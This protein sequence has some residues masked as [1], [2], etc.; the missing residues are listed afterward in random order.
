MMTRL[1]RSLAATRQSRC[2]FAS[3]VILAAGLLSIGARRACAQPAPVISKASPV[4]AGSLRPGDALRL[5]V[6]REPE[7][8]GEFMVDEHGQVTLPRLGRRTV[9]DVP[10]DSV[11]AR[12]IREYDEILRDATIEITPLYRV[13]VTG[14]V[15]NPGLFTV[16][17]TMSIADAIGLAGGVSPQGRNGR[18]SLVR[19][20][21][22]IES[23]SPSSR[24]TDLGL[25]SADEIFVPE[26]SW[27]SRNVALVIG[28]ISATASLLWAFRR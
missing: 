12:V 23:V 6:S 9:Q 19:D 2:R 15:R 25:R 27:L 28:G 16:D 11:R 7:L 21:Q 14:A 17:P 4:G 10:V 20:G 13:R 5:R 26:R 1:V 3:G 22:S 18:V 8:T 24:L